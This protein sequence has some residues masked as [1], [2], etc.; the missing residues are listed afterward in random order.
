MRSHHHD[1]V[2]TLFEF[3]LESSEGFAKASFHPNPSDGSSGLPTDREPQSRMTKIVLK[4]IDQQGTRFTS[5]S[6]TIDGLEFPFVSQ[7]ETSTESLGM[8][9][10]R[11]HQSFSSS[12]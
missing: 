6:R 2:E 12:R 5:M 9:L 1:V 8:F 11:W 4:C 7:P 10:R 3:V